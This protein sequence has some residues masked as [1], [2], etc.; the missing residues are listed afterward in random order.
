MFFKDELDI[1]ISSSEK[2]ERLLKSNLV[3]WKGL[4]NVFRMK[5]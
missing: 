3:D 4:A 2:Y 1:A 5:K